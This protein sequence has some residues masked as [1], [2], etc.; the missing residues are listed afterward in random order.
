MT[1]GRASQNWRP[2]AF[3]VL[4]LSCRDL[5]QIRSGRS[6]VDLGQLH[7]PVIMLVQGPGR[8]DHPPTLSIAE[9]RFLPRPSAL[10]VRA[11]PWP[12]GTRRAGALR[13]RAPRHPD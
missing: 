5:R 12:Y 1:S 7:G 8:V 9:Q 2:A 11:K 4:E 6:E 13:A 10:G 3:S